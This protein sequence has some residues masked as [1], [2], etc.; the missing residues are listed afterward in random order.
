MPP[1]ATI[2]STWP[3][4]AAPATRPRANAPP[5]LIARMPCGK[6]GWVVAE[7]SDEVAEQHRAVH[8]DGECRSRPSPRPMWRRLGQA[9]PG[10]R[11]EHA[12]NVDRSQAAKVESRQ[13]HGEDRNSPLH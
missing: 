3:S 13:V 2:T 7:A 8:V 9:D 4:S 6:G 12:A 1:P 5:M 10:Q 11:P